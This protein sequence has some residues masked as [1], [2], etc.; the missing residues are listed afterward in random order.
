MK[1]YIDDFEIPSVFEGVVQS[2][3]IWKSFR[4]WFALQVLLC[5]W[6]QRT[7]S[8]LC[9]VEGLLAWTCMSLQNCQLITALNIGHVQGPKCFFKSA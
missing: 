8:Q 2:I 9:S 7:V 5:I 4:K 1:S 6:M 3:C